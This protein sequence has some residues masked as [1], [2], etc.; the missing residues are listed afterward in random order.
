VLVGEIREFADRAKAAG[1][2]ASLHG[3]PD[4]Q[5]LFLLGAG[6]V[7]ETDAAITEMGEWLRAKLRVEG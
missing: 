4:G 5:H 3:V 6:Q 7:P 2:D 1:L